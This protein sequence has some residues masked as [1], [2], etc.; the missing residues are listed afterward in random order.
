MNAV[1]KFVCGRCGI[2]TMEYAFVAGMVVIVAALAY[3]AGLGTAIEA[4]IETLLP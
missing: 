2:E 4:Y 1:K 3:S